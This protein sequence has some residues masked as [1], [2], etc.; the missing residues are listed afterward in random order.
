MN[1]FSIHLFGLMVIFLL[2]DIAK[3]KCTYIML[4][5]FFFLL[6]KL[7]QNFLVISVA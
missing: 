4:F 5:Y 6:F 2:K 1:I 7:S 3:L